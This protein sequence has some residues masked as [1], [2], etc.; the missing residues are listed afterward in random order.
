MKTEIRI[1]HG[2]KELKSNGYRMKREDVAR[3]FP[4]LKVVGVDSFSVFAGYDPENPKAP[5]LPVTRKIYYKVNGTKHKCDARCRHAKGHNCECSCG[6][7]FHGIG[8]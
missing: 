5:Q 7:R 6:G 4:G 2:D 8:A 3:E 1:F